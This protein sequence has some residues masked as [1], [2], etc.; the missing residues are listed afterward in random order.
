MISSQYL[1]ISEVTANFLANKHADFL[2]VSTSASA[3]LV[4]IKVN[5]HC[6][7]GVR[8]CS[9]INVAMK[10]HVDVQLDPLT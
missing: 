9:Q 8:V 5:N 10:A 1:S 7:G 6:Q 2:K 3:V 4:E